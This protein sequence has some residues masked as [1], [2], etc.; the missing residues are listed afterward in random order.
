MFN[1]DKF[2]ALIHYVCWLSRDKPVDLGAVKLNKILWFSEVIAFAKNGEP[3]TGARFVKQKFGPVP[4]AIVPVLKELQ[5]EG[6]LNVIEVEY[7]GRLKQQYVCQADPDPVMLSDDERELVNEIAS[8]I[9]SDHTAT[10]IS[11]LTHDAIWKL[12]EIGNDIPFHAVLAS[13]LGKLSDKEIAAAR[14]RME[15][16]AA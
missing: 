5:S 14:R 12:A 4:R 6:T 13:S 3:I 10:S 11:D 15:A 9:T 1:R 8:A 7:Y 2:K 16:A